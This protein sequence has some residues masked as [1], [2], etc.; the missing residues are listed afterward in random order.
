MEKKQIE[1]FIKKYSLNGIIEGVVWTNINNDLHTTTITTDKKLFATVQLEKAATFFTD[2]E[3]GIQDTSKLKKMLSPLA[4]NF[5]FSLDLDKTDNNRVRELI[6]DDGKLDIRYVTAQK[7]TIPEKPSL[8]NIP[9]YTIVINIT[10]DFIDLFQK[11]FSAIGD[12]STLFTL[13]MSKKKQKLELVLGYKQMLSDRIAI[14]VDAV[15]GKDVVKSPIS[16]S[17]KHL[18]EIFSAN[19]DND[20]TILSVSEAGLANINFEENGCKS[21]YYMIKIDVE[22]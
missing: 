17:A 22:D 1:S 5:S 11:S 12:D 4:D 9:P 8:K 10:P 20:G 18:K 16:F 13:I 21:Q 3:I 15:I 19:N 14:Q 2:V 7:D 6:A